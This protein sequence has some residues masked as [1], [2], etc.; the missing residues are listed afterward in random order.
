M[1]ESSVVYGL[2]TIIMVF[3]G[4]FASRRQY[5]YEKQFGALSLQ[6]PLSFAYLEIWLP[7]IIFAIVFGCRYDVGID[8]MT[9]LDYYLGRIPNN[10]EFLWRHSANILNACGVHY[11]IYFAIWA[12]LQIFL[13][14]YAIKDYR[15]LFPYIAFY[16]MAGHF[17]LTYMN[18]IRV[19]LASC[20]FF[21][22][23]KF[24]INRKFFKYCLCVLVASLIHKTAIVLLLFYPLLVRKDDWFSIKSQIIILI[25]AIVLWINRDLC[26][27]VL[28]RFF[29]FFI[30]LFNYQSGY[31][32]AFN[33][34]RFGTALFEQGAHLGR[35]LGIGQFIELF[36]GIVI[37][38]FQKRL[39]KKYDTPLFKISY[40]L[41][42]ISFVGGILAG[43]SYVL[44]RPLLYFMNFKMLIL[45]YFTHYCFS[46]KK[47]NDKIIGIMFVL[48]YM[49]LFINIISM[50]EAN[51]S[52]F[53]FFWQH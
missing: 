38:A 46:S 15:F 17:F 19:S 35:N 37:I 50:G 11:A 14:Y 4:S 45:A 9:Y 16:L 13:V 41:W 7:I 47:L 27:T 5:S 36:I 18:G 2:L 52:A 42:F 28:T 53:T 21:C 22:S 40:T 49:A 43:K 39:K 24:I 32:Y 12:F 6:K 30:E 10:K 1:L 33:N 3:C 48:I 26:L 29:V 51:K 44:G 20:I 23:T 31:S 34:S 8:Q 25:V